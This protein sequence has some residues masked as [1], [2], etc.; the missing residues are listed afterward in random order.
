MSPITSPDSMRACVRAFG[1]DAGE[2]EVAGW[3]G[4][5][6]F[7]LV[8]FATLRLLLRDGIA[9]MGLLRVP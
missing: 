7:E 8:S 4:E 2:R 5:R 1:G 6:E 3:L 9:G